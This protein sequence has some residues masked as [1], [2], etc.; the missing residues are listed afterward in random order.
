MKLQDLKK[1]IKYNIIQDFPNKGVKFIDFTPTFSNSVI[2]NEIAEYI[3]EYLYDKKHLD[4]KIDYIIMPQSR[5]YIIGSFLSSN[6]N[7]DT[8]PIVKTGKL[9]DS[10]LLSKCVYKTE[11]SEDSLSLPKF[12]IYNKNCFFVD[13][14]FATGGTYECCKRMIESN[15]GVLLGGI[16]LYDVGITDEYKDEVESILKSEDIL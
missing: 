6:M 14:V 1:E 12:D 2:M 16:C 13:D 5:G 10:C 9:P 15:G 7:I 4:D 8:I 11:Y 3:A